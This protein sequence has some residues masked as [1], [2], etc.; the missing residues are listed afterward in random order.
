MRKEPGSVSGHGEPTSKNA[1]KC[2]IFTRIPFI[3]AIR[4]LAITLI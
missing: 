1:K 4:W 3:G 2:T